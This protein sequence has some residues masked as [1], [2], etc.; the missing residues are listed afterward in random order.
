MPKRVD[1]NQR[2]IIAA[3]RQFGATI[4]DSHECGHGAPDFVCG[5]AGKT[6]LFEVKAPGGKLTPDE[7]E[8]HKAWKGEPIYII[9]SIEDAIIIIMERLEDD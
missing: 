2:E 7:A 8:F 9:H 5:Y 4:W 1:Q 3:L 6:F